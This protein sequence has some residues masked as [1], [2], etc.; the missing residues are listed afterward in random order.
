MMM[1]LGRFQITGD[2]Q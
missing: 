1:Q 2:K